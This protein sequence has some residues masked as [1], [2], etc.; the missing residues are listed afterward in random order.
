MNKKIP[1]T[2]AGLSV[3][4]KSEIVRNRFSG[5]PVELEPE[6][7][8]MYDAIIGAEALGMYSM[9]QDGL[10]WFRQNHPK[11]FMILLD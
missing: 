5:D 11:A 6:A 4:A 7:L 8:A 3:G 10:A 1:A 9:V 2:F